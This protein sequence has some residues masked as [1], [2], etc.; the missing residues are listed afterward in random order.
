[1][2]LFPGTKLERQS[3][4]SVCEHV[5]LCTP[6]HVHATAENRQRGRQ[7]QSEVWM[8][9]SA[10]AWVRTETPF[11]YEFTMGTSEAEK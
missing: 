3:R 2:A 11:C 7:W 6:T 8:P 4:T 9:L 1:M 10:T 5:D